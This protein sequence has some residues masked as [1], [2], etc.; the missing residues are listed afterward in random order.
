MKCPVCNESTI[1]E[2][3]LMLDSSLVVMQSCSGCDS[4]RWI[5][6]G[7]EVAVEGILEAASRR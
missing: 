2:V 4:R 1:V 5:K 3:K 7:D 6:D